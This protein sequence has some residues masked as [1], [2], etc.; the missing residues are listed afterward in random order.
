ML[1]IPHP[2]EP[3]TRLPIGII[4]LRGQQ[5]RGESGYLH[6]QVIVGFA[7]KQSLAGVRCFFASAHAE[8]TRS[9]HA[10]DYVW[11]DATSVDGTRFELGAKPFCRNSKV[12]WEDCWKA[13][14]AGDLLKIPAH[15]R[16]VS[17]RTIRAIG[18]DYDRPQAVE[19]NASVYWG[20]TGVGKSRL[21]WEKAGMDAY[22][23]DPRSKFWC[24]YQGEEDVIIDEFRGG[25]AIGH[26]L[27]WLDRYPVRVE[28]KGSSRPLVAPRI[29]ITSNLAPSDWYPDADAATV[30]ALMRR[31]NIVEFNDTTYDSLTL[32]R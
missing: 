4:W 11:K 10:A 18:A 6:W 32:L 26:I 3:P 19:R 23:K 25:I 14:Q 2:F 17:Y 22:P 9:K 16:F 24:G 8:L 1:T 20:P 15:V 5:E 12:E 29:W 28:L 27:R 7:A 21:A 30:A 31:L 13:A